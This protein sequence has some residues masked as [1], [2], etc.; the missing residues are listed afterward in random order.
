MANF[1]QN[2]RSGG[3]GNRGSWSGGRD[4]SR[5]MHKAI[6][7]NCGNECEVPFR[8][9]GDRPVYCSNCFEKRN[10][11][12]SHPR[13][14]TDRGFQRPRFEERQSQRPTGGDRDNASIQINRQILDQLTS[15]NVKLDK[16]ITVLE[17]KVVAT[18]TEKPKNIKIPAAKKKSNKKT[19]EAK[20]PDQSSEVSPE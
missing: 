15:L 17:P 12:G 2:N 18:K 16:I 19:I 1:H 20:L 11:E 5:M 10:S 13:R 6:C 4:S 9:S 14:P 3:G 7:A 8:P